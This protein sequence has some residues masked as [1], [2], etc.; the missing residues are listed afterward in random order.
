MMM[1]GA[2]ASLVPLAF[3]ALCTW[4]SV[5]LPKRLY[6]GDTVFLNTFS[7]LLFRFRPGAHSY[8]LVLLLRNFALAVVPVIPDVAFQLFSSAAV[9]MACVLF[10]LSMS[11][12]AVHQANHLDVAMHAGLLFILL[13]AALQTNRV[14]EMIVGQLL[15]AVFSGMMCAFLGASAWSL[16]LCAVR[17]R[18]PFQFFLCHHKVGGGAFCR[19]LKVR[20]LSREQVARDVFLDSDNLQDLSLLFGVVAEKTET[21]VVL[22]TR[23]ILRRP[24]CVGEMTTARLHSIDTILVIFPQF[25]H[26]SRTFIEDYASVE[27]V[28]SLAPFGISVE[29]AQQT[30]WWLGAR[31]WIVLPRSISPAGVSAVVEKLVGRKRGTQEMAAVSFVKSI[32]ESPE[33]EEHVEKEETP[34]SHWRSGPTVSHHVSEQADWSAPATVAV[35]SVVDHTNQEAVCTALLVRELLKKFF[36]LTGPGHVLGPEENLPRNAT[37]LLVMSSNGCFQRPYFVRQLFQAE[38]LGIGAIPVIVDDSFRFPSDLF[39]QELRALSAH[40]LSQTDRDADDLIALIKKLFEEIGIHVRPQDSQGVLE[41]WDVGKR[42]CP[43]FGTQH[44]HNAR[45]VQRPSPGASPHV[46]RLWYPS[47]FQDGRLQD[48]RR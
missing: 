32:I 18:K 10:C 13:L 48:L 7:F 17:L 45:S 30:L 26:P 40:R 14:D 6:E 16:R 47:T 15:L 24:W 21:L 3:L 43:C 35:V 28:Q 34:V 8:V 2:C 31:P 19:L 29:M 41:V 38:R 37:M 23:E 1:S 36:P 33:N 42:K 25:E 46:V 5:S 22:C 11:P 20:L 4:V 44:P 27:G 39:F 12:W 9:V